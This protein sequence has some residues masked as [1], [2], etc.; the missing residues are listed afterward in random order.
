MLLVMAVVGI[1]LF[2]L[3]L[4][5]KVVRMFVNGEEE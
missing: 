4:V 5:V 1:G 3:L 2:G